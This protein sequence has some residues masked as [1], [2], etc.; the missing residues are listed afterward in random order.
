M[1]LL[2]KTLSRGFARAGG[3]GALVADLIRHFSFRK[4]FPD[5]LKRG[6]RDILD[7]FPGK[8]SLMRS[9]HHIVK[10]EEARKDVVR[11]DFV[12]KIFEEIVAFFLVNVQAG[13][14]D[15]ARFESSDEGLGIDQHAPARVDD[16][17]ALLHF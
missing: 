13:E 1:I 15:L 10:G 9:D 17:H 6:G 16:H 14:A 2:L 11:D 4:K 8:K 3:C 7:C 12:G 5:V